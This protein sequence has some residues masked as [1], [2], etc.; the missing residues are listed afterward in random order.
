M[1]LSDM[2]HHKLVHENDTVFFTFKGNHF[3][4]KILRG[5]LIGS[6][7]ITT[8]GKTRKILEGVTAFTS[9]TAWTE[10][11]LQDVLEEYYTRYSSWKRV[12]HK[13]SKRSMGDLRDQCKLLT[14]KRKRED[15][16]PELYKEIYR[17]QQKI[18]DM[19]MHIEQWENGDTPPSRDW[20]MVS[21]KPDVPLK[22]G[23]NESKLRAQY[24]A[25][26]EP[27]GIDLELYNILH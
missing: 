16:V 4:A 12:N 14:K 25:L 15:E 20:E 2:L 3:T 9:L 8:C 17:L 23:E 27:R 24:I 6:C 10:A 11:C 5:G 18:V 7:E 19:K 13:E 1:S 22:Q 21:I 26:G